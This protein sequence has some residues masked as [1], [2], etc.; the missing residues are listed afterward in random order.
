[1]Q[2]IRSAG[3][4]AVR[5]YGDRY[6]AAVS[7]AG[8][9]DARGSSERALSVVIAGQYATVR[10]PDALAVNQVDASDADLQKRVDSGRLAAGVDTESRSGTLGR[11]VACVL[12]R[13]GAGRR[14]HV[15]S[16]TGT[17]FVDLKIKQ[18]GAS[19]CNRHALK[20]KHV[21]SAYSAR[22]ARGDDIVSGAQVG[23]DNAW[24][25]TATA[26]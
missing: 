8:V 12:A 4:R 15:V 7:G 20:A 13:R 25:A 24:P 19:A 3:A 5:V 23:L 22:A 2:L 11:V 16:G 6:D 21:D 18:R 10:R 14:E 9:R 1:M 26:S 17:T